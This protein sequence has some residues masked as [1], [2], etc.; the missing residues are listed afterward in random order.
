[1]KRILPAAVLVLLATPLAAHAKPVS[2]TARAEPDSL[3][4]ERLATLGRVWGTAKFF[5]PALAYR[6]VDWD[7]ALLETIP[8]VD[9]AKSE[10]DLAAAYDHL[11]SFLDDS[12]SR[13]W[14][15]EDADAAE[16]P[17]VLPAE[18]PAVVPIG[19]GLVRVV[20]HRLGNVD[21]CRRGNAP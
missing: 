4:V 14:T 18:P 19:D 10:R 17:M 21:E 1:M 11:L 2:L 7:A 8:L 5:H 15:P 20:A 13:T 9:A 12:Y 3:A 6:E 16:V